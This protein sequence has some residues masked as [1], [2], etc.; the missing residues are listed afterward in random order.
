MGFGWL[1]PIAGVALVGYRAMTW[2]DHVYGDILFMKVVD[3]PLLHFGATSPM[4]FVVQF[5][6]EEVGLA[7]HAHKQNTQQTFPI[8]GCH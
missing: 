1:R 4:G 7:C 8:L 6:C 3:D 5:G 2:F